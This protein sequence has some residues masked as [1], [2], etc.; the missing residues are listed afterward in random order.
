[1]L[2]R[3]FSQVA[4][5]DWPTCA[6]IEFPAQTTQLFPLFDFPSSQSTHCVAPE[7]T[8]SPAA[9]LASDPSLHEL[10]SEAPVPLIESAPQASQ[11]KLLLMLP[12]FPASQSWHKP[13][14]A[15]NQYSPP[16]HSMQSATVSWLAAPLPEVNLPSSHEVQ[17]E[18][19]AAAL[20]E[21]EGQ[22]LQLA[23][24]EEPALLKVPTPHSSQAVFAP[25]EY[26]PPAQIEHVDAPSEPE[27]YPS[28]QSSHE[29]CSRADWYFPVSQAEH[30]C[31]ETSAVA[32]PGGHWVQEMLPV[33]L[34]CFPPAQSVQAAFPVMFANFPSTQTV[35][36]FVAEPVAP[37]YFPVPQSAHSGWPSCSLY[38]PAAQE[39]QAD[40]A[41]AAAELP[42]FPAAQEI[43]TSAPTR[44]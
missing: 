29:V 18:E 9:L 41:V 43:H 31:W 5:A 11:P 7:V 24:S 28:A 6:A 36:T 33:P 35:Q 4:Q 1:M 42:A 2:T 39:T 37:E 27:T 34:A 20:K 30:C 10:Q 22:T 26:F 21:F 16:P 40:S 32:R 12:F 19:P 44:L 25:F 8:G 15:V 13:S 14:P 17:V 3:E 38:F 23:A